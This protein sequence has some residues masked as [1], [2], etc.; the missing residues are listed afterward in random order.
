MATYECFF[1]ASH[2]HERTRC[3]FFVCHEN[4]HITG[5]QVVETKKVAKNSIE[6]ESQ[7]LLLLLNWIKQ[8]IQVGSKINIYGDALGVVKDVNRRKKYK[9][10]FKIIQRDYDVTL[11]YIPRSRNDLADRLS[12]GKKAKFPVVPIKTAAPKSKEISMAN[13]KFCESEPDRL[14]EVSALMLRVFLEHNADGVLDESIEIFKK[15][16]SV[17]NFG[18]WLDW[19]EKLPKFF[20][21]WVCIDEDT[22]KVVGALSAYYD[23]LDNLF[24]DSRYH[25]KGIAQRLFT[26][27]LEYFN[28][29]EIKVCA[30]LYAQ[31][32][33]RK[34]GFVGDEEQIINK[35]QRVIMMTYHHESGERSEYYELTAL[36][37][38]LTEKYGEEKASALISEVGIRAILKKTDL[39]KIP[40]IGKKMARHLINA[41]YPYIKSLKGQDPEEIYHKDCLF[42]GKQ[43]D[44]CS[45]YC[46]RL[47]VHY[48]DNDG[49]LPPD[50]QKWWDWK[51]SKRF[52]I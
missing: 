3:A 18:E 30:S 42:Q 44:K 37:T 14:E 15:L 22:N 49:Q 27:M 25:R 33:Y 51:E 10:I 17:A 38:H 21:L 29:D 24:V 19:K 5:K 40:G 52:V 26:M 9:R 35:G 20:N 36:L 6:A 48:A 39:T 32:F 11:K 12:K 43:V 41:G 13:L 1:D 34:L 50:K 8:K 7:A 31:D 47:A 46:Y 16:T 45:L 2:T 23:R 28:P 4:G